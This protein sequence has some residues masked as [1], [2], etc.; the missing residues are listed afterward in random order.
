MSTVKE[1]AEQLGVHPSTVSRALN[2]SR[3]IS[4]EVREKVLATAKAM[5]YKLRGRGGRATPDWN[6]A[7]IIV[8]EVLSDYYARIV[9]LAKT[10]LAARGYST[11]VKI[12]SFTPKEM[13]EAINSMN[14][15]QVKCLLIVLDSEESFSDRILR[16]LYATHLPVVLLTSR[17]HASMNMDC[18]HLDENAGICMAIEHLQQR[19]HSEVGF[20]GEKMTAGRLMVFK[21]VMKSMKMELQP[22][23]ICIGKERMEEGGYLRMKELLN[24]PHPPKAVFCSYDQMAVGAIHAIQEA[25]KRVPE[26]IAVIGFDDIAAA[27]YVAGGITTVANPCKDMVSIAVSVLLSRVTAPDSAYQEIALRPT[28]MVRSTT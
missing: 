1:I 19:G 28:L 21:Q 13:L 23:W 2:G 11:I 9:H 17:F 27:P 18:I 7:G 16:S 8:P 24:L 20:I 25:G 22:Q 15:I 6:T 3:K 5:D 26:D 4:A 10:S 12:T 14:R